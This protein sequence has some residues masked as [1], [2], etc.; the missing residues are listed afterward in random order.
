MLQYEKFF[1]KL[2]S[3]SKLNLLQKGEYGPPYIP[4]KNILITIFLAASNSKLS[5]LEHTLTT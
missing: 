3:N 5:M 1:I 2:M 4:C